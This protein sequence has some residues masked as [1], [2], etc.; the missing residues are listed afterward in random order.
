MPSTIETMVSLHTD[1]I[2]QQ[3]SAA[4]LQDNLTQELTF[5]LQEISPYTLKDLL[6]QKALALLIKKHILERPLSDGIRQEV[7][8]T[9][10][11]IIHL[12]ELAQLTAGDCMD[13]SDI[14]KVIDYVLEQRAL[15]AKVVHQVL[16]NPVYS[17]VLS[18]LLYVSIK[19]YLLQENILTKKVPGVASLMKIGKGVVEKMGNLEENFEK[20]IKNYIR[21]N[22]AST[23][24]LSEQLILKAFDGPGIRNALLDFW[25][26]SKSVSFADAGGYVQDLHISQ[27]E[28][29]SNLIWNHL[30]V[31][32][33]VQAG[34]EQ[35]ILLFMERHSLRRVGEL[36]NDFELDLHALVLD[37]VQIIR[38][39]I[40]QLVQDGFIRQRIH[41]HLTEFYNSPAAKS[42]LGG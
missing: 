10:H 29:I 2:L 38:P 8:A 11:S 20:A 32:P 36:L 23:I 14:V 26:Q 13:T 17:D 24:A 41:A 34:V 5:L 37:L 21:K 31:L 25:E 40:D 4:A 22:I 42:L 28:E 39:G 9:I 30:R 35:L 7:R 16:S 27:G 18:D 19:D 3:L 15:R 33:Q 12:P 1:H 6:D